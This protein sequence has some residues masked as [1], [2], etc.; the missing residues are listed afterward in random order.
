MARETLTGLV[1]RQAMDSSSDVF[2]N[3]PDLIVTA[4]SPAMDPDMF[5]DPDGYHW[6][7]SV[8]PVNEAP[9]YLYVRAANYTIGSQRSRVYLYYAA[10]DQLLDPSKW[11]ASGFTVGGVEQH[12]VPLSARAR[13]EIVITNP[14]VMWTPP[15]PAGNAT[16]FL[17]SWVDN[18][19]APTP[20]NWPTTPFDSL[21]ALGQYVKDHDQ[22]A[23]LDTIY[24]GVF[25]RQFPKQ[26]V[27]APGTGAQTSP[28]LVVSGA[29]AAKDASAYT[30]PASYDAATLNAKAALGLRNF[31]YVRAINTTSGSASA[32]VYLYWTTATS[33]SPTSWNTTNFSYAGRQQ[34]WVDLTAAKTGDV[35]VSA[36]PLVWTAPPTA[37]PAAVLIAYVDNSA[38]PKPPDFS[39]FGYVTEKAVASFVAG[40]PQM[41]WLA[42]TGDT[43]PIPSMTS[44][45]RLTGSSWTQDSALAGI[46]FSRI[47]VDGTVSLSVPGPDAAST[48]VVTGMRVPDPNALVAW[49]ITW[50]DHFQTS[51]V[52]SYTEGATPPVNGNIIATL[53]SIPG[54]V[55][56]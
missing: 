55:P 42:L 17:I 4:A 32:R 13:R 11:Q 3:S 21:A 48:I 27:T 44:E 30:A 9:N 41:C 36:V 10:S 40:H 43:V 16:Y 39:P 22:M 33:P 8:S 45:V 26:S 14:P 51:A 2:T 28:D 38:S 15:K 25:L 47:P 24:R 5:T 19:D 20:P 12:W 37:D 50:P 18:S 29:T 56:G 7:F 54:P 1:I 52:I 46:K 31:I 53:A 49:P 23:V 34:N 35:M 6:Y